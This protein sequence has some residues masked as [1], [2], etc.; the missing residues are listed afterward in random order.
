MKDLLLRVDRYLS[1]EQATLGKLFVEDFFECFTLEDEY[2]AVK[3]MAETRIPEGT[4]E[5]KLL[6][7]GDHH[8]TYSKRFPE[9]HKGMLWLQDVPKFQGIL[10]HIG[11]TE[12][13]T[14][15]CLLIGAT[16]DEKTMT[17]GNSTI[18]Y[19]AFYPKIARAILEG[20]KVLITYKNIEKKTA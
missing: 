5:I 4:Y 14:A 18:A 19:K 10:I 15:G 11:N 8:N 7:T 9:F 16:K 1:S 20:R 6:T 3:V 13:D 2:R 12:K 17:I